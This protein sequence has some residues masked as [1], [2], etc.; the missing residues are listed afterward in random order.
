MAF[1][2]PRVTTDDGDRS[3]AW[4]AHDTS[5]NIAGLVGAGG[6]TI[7]LVK[8]SNL[9]GCI[10]DSIT[11]QNINTSST[12]T[13]LIP[14][15][16]SGGSGYVA[17]DAILLPNGV[18]LYAAT[19]SSGVVT[20]VTMYNCGTLPFTAQASAQAQVATT[21]SGTGFT[22]TLALK[23]SGGLRHTL[24]QGYASWAEMYA[25]GK[26]TFSYECN[27]GF[28]GQGT[29]ELL[30]MLPYY[31]ARCAAQDVST[32]VALIGTNDVVVKGRSYATTTANLASI[33][34]QLVGSGFRVIAV[35]ILP[36]SY[37]GSGDT[38]LSASNVRA[39]LRINQWIIRYCRDNIGM[40]LA[41]PTLN[42]VD[43]TSAT[44]YP[45]PATVKSTASYTNNSNS[46]TYDGLHPTPCG[47]QFIGKAIAT[48]L[49][50]LYTQT[51]T[52]IVSTADTYNA[53]DNPTGNI[54][55]NGLFN[56]AS[57]GTAGTGA[58]GT[59]VGSF[60]LNRVTGSN[61]TVVASVT[62]VTNDNGTT[63]NQQTLALDTTVSGTSEAWRFYQQVFSGFSAGD[64]IYCEC[65][66]DVSGI[67]SAALANAY[68]ECTDGI[69][70][71]RS[72]NL[73]TNQVQSATSYSGLLRTPP[74]TVGAG[75]TVVQF[76]VNMGLIGASKTATVKL[77]KCVLRKV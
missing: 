66:I 18:I 59:V 46:W 28:S 25:G 36:R 20:A 44:G 35:P 65:E 11:A 63:Y 48:V 51:D 1:Y 17:N 61:G 52:R 42:W 47:A 32:V 4:M 14:T 7:P 10:G 27:W 73:T 70:T 33:Y 3:Q 67:P 8:P 19:V 6:V 21:G 24:A 74:L 43:L 16:V 75:A 71:A 53:S 26:A 45:I 37:D 23:G 9:F 72:M 76:L 12:T 5:G 50:S 57:G 54:L 49:S 62:T 39:I 34:A 60:T 29:T 58:S 41:D 22:A 64:Q 77:G 2:I 15:I 31:M 40:Y 30:T 13:T 56:T 55:A 38:G 68:L 69:T